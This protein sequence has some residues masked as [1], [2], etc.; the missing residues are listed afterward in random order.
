V[1][2][3]MELW[4]EV[5]RQVLTGELTKRAARRKYHLH[6]DTLTKILEN[7]EPPGYRQRQQREKPVLGPFLPLIQEILE[8][9]KKAPPKQ[10]HTAKRIFERLRE[11]G[12]TGGLTVVA[13][14]VRRIKERSAEVFMPLSHRPGEA[15]ADFGEATVVYR[16]QERKIAFFV[17][18]LPYSDAIF[19]Q[20]F[21]RECTESFQEGHRRA[22]EFFGGVPKR[23][24]YDNSRIAVTKIIQKR[25]GAFTAEFLRLESHYLFAHHFCLVRRPCEKGHTETLVGYSRRNFMVPVPEFDDFEVFNAQLAGDCQQ[26]LQRKLR[27]KAD[28]KAVLLEEDRQAMLPLPLNPFEARRV[29]L[30]QASS[31]SLVR[32]DCN[33]YSVPTQ[34][35]HQAVMAIGGIEKVRFVVRDRMVAEHPRDWGKENVHYDPVHYLALLERKPGALD[36]GKP[37]D[38]WD[39]PE[40]FGILRRRLEGEL[41]QVGRREFIKVLRLLEWCELKELARAV[42][43]ALQIGAFTVEAVRLLLQDGREEPA[44]YFRLD[45]RPHLQGHEVPPPNLAAYNMLRQDA[46]SLTFHETSSPKGD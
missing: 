10:R 22:F 12:Y 35:A 26:D 38:D 40:V 31:L 4:S 43:R 21:P 41:G 42:D 3:N 11:R 28:I 19:C 8:A 14:E 17:M 33:D 1:Y 45:G 29:E 18:T 24:S 9:D 15:Q 39:L 30:C 27:G 36:F 44:K 46:A 20:A 13:D 16:G 6:W 23:I 37:F 34:Y 2:T 32:F 25:G 5:R 7:P